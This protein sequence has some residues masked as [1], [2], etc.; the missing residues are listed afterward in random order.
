MP[1]GGDTAP[2]T[3]PHAP[4]SAAEP[5]GAGDHGEDAEHDDHGHAEEPLGPIDWVAWG[6]GALGVGIGVLIAAGF[7]L[8]AGYLGA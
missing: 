4:Q 8:S 3:D 2:M 6:T 1:H 7:A 5:H